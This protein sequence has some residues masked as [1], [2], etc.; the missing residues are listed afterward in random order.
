M[1]SRGARNIVLTSRNPEVDDKWLQYMTDAG[2]R[3]KVF[4]K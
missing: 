1:A 3:V 4:A 2:V